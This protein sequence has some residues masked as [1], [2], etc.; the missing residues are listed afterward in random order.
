M[1]GIGNIRVLT[2]ANGDVDAIH[3]DSGMTDVHVA[4]IITVSGRNLIELEV[5]RDLRFDVRQMDEVPGQHTSKSKPPGESDE[6]DLHIAP[7]RE[8]I[9][10]FRQMTPN[11][12]MLATS[13]IFASS[14]R[15]CTMS[16]SGSCSNDTPSCSSSGSNLKRL[17]ST[18]ERSLWRVSGTCA[19]CGSVR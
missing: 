15:M 14:R 19:T 17:Y 8:T 5:I 1:N 2:I 6:T 16:S 13:L 4:V 12:S 7:S 18:S 10:A 3:S 11:R 9:L